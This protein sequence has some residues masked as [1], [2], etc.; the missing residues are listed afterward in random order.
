M[1]TT[2]TV[3]QVQ[4]VYATVPPSVISGPQGGISGTAILHEPDNRYKYPNIFFCNIRNKI[5]I[6]WKLITHD[7]SFS[8]GSQGGPINSLTVQPTPVIPGAASTDYPGSSTTPIVDGE[9]HAGGK[10]VILPR[11]EYL[12]RTVLAS[13]MTLLHNRIEDFKTSMEHNLTSL[14]R[15]AYEHRR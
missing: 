13:N 1:P 12:V 10:D 15:N 8:L 11:D 9:W 3:T 5:Q 6:Y 4:T 2:F 14:Y 7:F